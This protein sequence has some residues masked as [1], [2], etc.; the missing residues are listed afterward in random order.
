MNGL[1]MRPTRRIGKTLYTIFT[2]STKAIHF[3]HSEIPFGSTGEPA[4]PGVVS[5]SFDGVHG[6]NPSSK[7]VGGILSW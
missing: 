2:E 5:C 3:G 4:S 7:L 1:V 6:G